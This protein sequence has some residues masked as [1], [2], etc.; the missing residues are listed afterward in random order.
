MSDPRLRDGLMALLLLEIADLRALLAC[1]GPVHWGG[2]G[3]AQALFSSTMALWRNRGA[4]ALNALGFAGA[5]LAVALLLAPIVGLLG[6]QL[7]TLVSVLS[8]IVLFD[9][10][11]TARS[12]SASWTASDRLP[13]QAGAQV[14]R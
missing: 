13:G 9:G 4:F 14:T 10:V 12:T 7:G 6:P 1:T 3:V 5:V 2:Q 8:T 11:L